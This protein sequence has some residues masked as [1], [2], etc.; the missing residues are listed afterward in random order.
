MN[1]LLPCALLCLSVAC[2]PYVEEA[3][4]DTGGPLSGEYVAGDGGADGSGGGGADEGGSG[5]DGADGSSD[6]DLGSGNP[7]PSIVLPAGTWT[8][9]EAA[10]TRDSCAAWMG[11]GLDA[12]G[13][14]LEA[15]L[16]REFVVQPTLDG[17]E[18]EAQTFGAAAPIDCVVDGFAFECERQTVVPEA[19]GLGELGWS[20]AI[21][22]S[23]RIPD[24]NTNDNIEGVA[25]VSYTGVDPDTRAALRGAGIDAQDCDQRVY[26]MLGYRY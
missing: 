18:I 3:D 26:L 6:S 10:V 25:T 20:Y 7:D 16:P 5:G 21:D 22:F 8:N 24:L 2:F 15:F 11:P 1:R 12:L 19:Y 23:G 4:D 14:D 17:F 13:L 9:R